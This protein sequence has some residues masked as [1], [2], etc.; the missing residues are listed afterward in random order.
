MMCAPSGLPSMNH[1]QRVRFLYKAILQ[2]HRALPPDLRE[3]GN[4]FVREEFR[5]HIKSPPEFT[6]PFMVEW[7]V[8][9]LV[10]PVY[11]TQISCFAVR[12]YAVEL[13]KQVRDLPRAP[14]TN[15]SVDKAAGI[16]GADLDESKINHFSEAQLQQLLALAKAIHCPP[17]EGQS[18]AS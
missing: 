12:R 16:I 2:L 8:G 6:G 7:S 17:S 4:K 10:S 13:S 14:S 1:G 11:A 9:F 15:Q 3:L 5:K 18:E